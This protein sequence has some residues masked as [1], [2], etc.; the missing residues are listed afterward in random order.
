MAKTLYDYWFVQFDFP[1]SEGKPYRSSGGE[2]VWCDELKREVPKGWGGA[3][4]GTFAD[5]YQ[6]KTISEKEMID[7]GKYLVY[8]ANGIVGRYSEY[9]H[10]ESVVTIT[11]RGN[12]CG[13]LN[14][15]RPLSWITGN[16]MVVKPKKNIYSIDFIYNLLLSSNV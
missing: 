13:T 2:M 14:F 3:T 15:T 1:N 9:N 4:L 11:C 5:L 10:E 16:A 7:N 6:P 8:G 12:S